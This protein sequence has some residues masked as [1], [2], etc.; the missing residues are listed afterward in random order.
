MGIIEG[1]K[2]EGV[3]GIEYNVVTAKVEDLL[4]WARSRS[5]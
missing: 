4:Q 1:I 3:N 5:I 2:N